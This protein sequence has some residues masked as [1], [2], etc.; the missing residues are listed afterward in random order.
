MS[1]SLISSQEPYSCSQ[2]WI[3]RYQKHQYIFD[4]IETFDSLS[5]YLTQIFSS[6]NKGFESSGGLGVSFLLAFALGF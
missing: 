5:T 3:D 2:Y 4:W 1:L 6:L